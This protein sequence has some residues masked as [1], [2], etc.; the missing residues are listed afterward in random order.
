MGL[1]IDF[2][3]DSD[4]YRHFINGHNAVMHCH[5]Y[6]SLTTQLVE[7][8]ADAGGREILASC[9]EDSIRPLLDEYYEKNSI[10]DLSTRLQVGSEF[11]SFLGLGKMAVRDLGNGAGEALLTR[12]H[13]DEG[14]V[15]KFGPSDRP[16]NHFT[17]GFVAAVFAAAHSKPAQSIAVVEQES[18]ATGAPQGRFAATPA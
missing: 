15:Q 18:M 10:T 14:W 16:I 17:C 7:Q 12:S 1:K 4:T 9:A 3:F 5:H 11:Y 2:S 8:F 13:V 6:M